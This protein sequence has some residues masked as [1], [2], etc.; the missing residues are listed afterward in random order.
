M[1][2]L[3]QG[4]EKDYNSLSRMLFSAKCCTGGS[5]ITPFLSSHSLLPGR[6]LPFVSYKPVFFMV[7]EIK[8]C[9]WMI[10]LLLQQNLLYFIML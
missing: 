10:Q 5:E 7:L 6:M 8:A 3:R 9:A 1:C 4:H 2:F